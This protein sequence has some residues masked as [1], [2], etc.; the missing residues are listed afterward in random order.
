M[1]LFP[2]CNRI[3]TN[4][5]SESYNSAILITP[6]LIKTIFIDLDDTLWATQENNRDTLEELYHLYGWQKG[7][8]SFEAFFE[9]YAPHN[10]HLWSEYREGK[11]TKKEL[12]LRRFGYP[13]EALGIH[14]EEDILKINEEFLSRT[15]KKSK[16]EP[17][18]IKLL[19]Y[20]Y[21][22]FQVVV[23]SNGFLEVQESK[24]RSSG[25]LPY[26]H[27]IV[28]SEV[29]GASKPDASIFRYAFNKSQSRPGEV[30]L[31]GDSWEADIIGAQNAKIPSIW[32]NPMG[33]P[34]PI[35]QYRYPIYEVK[36][37]SEVPRI[38]R[39]LLPL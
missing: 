34:R 24:M 1:K 18:A 15:A 7:Y 26:I 17:G 22:L 19:E 9:K 20:L 10:E 28:L 35:G 14:S 8:H 32:Y 5:C 27:H 4:N 6:T 33:L 25:I 38:L 3:I 39:S 31:I 23:V 16:T 12:T 30:L 21:G 36:H 2:S 37:L 13:L 11:I 29:A